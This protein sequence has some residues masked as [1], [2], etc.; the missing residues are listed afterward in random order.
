MTERRTN[1]HNSGF[2]KYNSFWDEEEHKHHEEHKEKHD[3]DHQRKEKHDKDCKNHQRKEK[4]DKNCES[5]NHH[6]QHCCIAGPT[7]NIGP[8]GNVGP[9]GQASELPYVRALRFVRDQNVPNRTP[10]TITNYNA[11]EGDYASAFDLTT[12]IFTAPISGLWLAVCDLTFQDFTNGPDQLPV[13]SGG[14]RSFRFVRP[15]NPAFIGSSLTINNPIDQTGSYYTLFN[16]KLSASGV[17][18]IAAGDQISILAYQDNELENNITTN[19]DLSFIRLRDVFPNLFN[20][21]I[22]SVNGY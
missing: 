3:K 15:D 10:I 20:S 16:T 21:P 4:H 12:G 8:T 14:A 11:V 18:P 9:T 2:D 1:K 7:G 22:I 6:N 17:F 5:H 19:L 13:V